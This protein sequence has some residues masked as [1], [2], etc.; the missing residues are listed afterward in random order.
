MKR[1]KEKSIAQWCWE[2]KEKRRNRGRKARWFGKETKKRKTVHSNIG[3][4]EGRRKTGWLRDEKYKL[5]NIRDSEKQRR[6][7]DIKRKLK[8]GDGV[9]RVYWK[10]KIPL[11][12]KKKKGNA[13]WKCNLKCQ[14]YSFPI[15]IDIKSRVRFAWSTWPIAFSEGVPWQNEFS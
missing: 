2:G 13:G 12:R 9:L 3:K 14:G 8:T 6:R 7:D 15:F 10:G 5:K 1:L 4:E 11:S